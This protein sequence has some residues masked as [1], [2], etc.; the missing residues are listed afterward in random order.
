MVYKYLVKG[1]SVAPFDATS[2]LD[3]FRTRL[4]SP[5]IKIISSNLEAHSNQGLELMKNYSFIKN[6][7]YRNQ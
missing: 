5:I 7:L 6:I 2:N 4:C 3:C 1:K